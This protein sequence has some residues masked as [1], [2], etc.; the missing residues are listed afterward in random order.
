MFVIDLQFGAAGPAYPCW[1]GILLASTG[2]PLPN[3][4]ELVGRGMLSSPPSGIGAKSDGAAV[5][6][7]F[8]RFYQYI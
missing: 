3:A 2:V 7:G 1:P 4:V 8:P 5:C 6:C